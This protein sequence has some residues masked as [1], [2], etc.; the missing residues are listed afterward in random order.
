MGDSWPTDQLRTALSP[1]LEYT[2]ASFAMW[3]TGQAGVNVFVLISNRISVCGPEE[4]KLT[5]DS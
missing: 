4:P 5:L 3:H 1:L 2:V